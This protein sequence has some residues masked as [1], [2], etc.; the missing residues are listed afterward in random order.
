MPA[1]FR[2]RAQVIP[3]HQQAGE[4]LDFFEACDEPSTAQEGRV[5]RF[6][7]HEIARWPLRKRA[8]MSLIL[9]DSYRKY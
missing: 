3:V 5:A 4:K 1:G 7:L 6:S 8:F 2:R 9:Q